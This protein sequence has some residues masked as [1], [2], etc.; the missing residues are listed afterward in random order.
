MHREG[1]GTLQALS[2]R[3]RPSPENLEAKGVGSLCTWQTKPDLSLSQRHLCVRE[4]CTLLYDS[5]VCTR[6]VLAQVLTSQPFL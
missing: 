5:R 6:S 4:G 2:D 1:T 3:L